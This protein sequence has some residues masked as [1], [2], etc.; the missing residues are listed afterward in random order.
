MDR[1]AGQEPSER[2]AVLAGGVLGCGEGGDAEEGPDAGVH[3]HA[4]ARSFARAD[5]GDVLDTYHKVGAT[6]FLVSP[7]GFRL[8]SAEAA[9]EDDTQKVK[10]AETLEVLHRVN[11]AYQPEIRAARAK[12]LAEHPGYVGK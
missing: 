2:G 7:A 10:L 1:R 4:A 6:L 8:R 3:C 11:A 12:Y 5:A 9:V